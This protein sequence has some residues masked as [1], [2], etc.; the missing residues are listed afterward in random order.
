MNEQDVLDS[1]CMDCRGIPFNEALPFWVYDEHS[2]CECENGPE[3]N[4]YILEK[5]NELA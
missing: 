3:T 1:M 4:Y 5:H 2:E